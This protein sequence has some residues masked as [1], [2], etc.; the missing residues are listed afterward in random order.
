MPSI[1][2]P[3]RSYMGTFLQKYLDVLGLSQYHLS[4]ESGM[5]QH[6]ICRAMKSLDEKDWKG[7]GPLKC[8]PLAA[9]ITHLLMTNRPSH[10]LVI[11]RT[12]GE[13]YA[14]VLAESREAHYKDAVSKDIARLWDIYPSTAIED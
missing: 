9:A 1:V 10:D 4:R 5:E 7:I 11:G 2:S 14:H 8:Y 12:Y 3:K 13:V 6:R